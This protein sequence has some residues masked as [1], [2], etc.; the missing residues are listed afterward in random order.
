MLLLFAS[1]SPFLGEK[2]SFLAQDRFDFKIL[3]PPPSFLFIN[4]SQEKLRRLK[5]LLGSYLDQ[6]MGEGGLVSFE[7]GSKTSQS[8]NFH[9]I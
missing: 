5:V 4:N 6:G 7:R 9:F 3:P 8:T 2:K 1:K